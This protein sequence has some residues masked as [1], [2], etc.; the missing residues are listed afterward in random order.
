MHAIQTGNALARKQPGDGLVG[1]DHQVLDQAVGLGLHARANLGDVSAL[2]EDELG[3]LGVDRQR[4]APLAR[5][6]QSASSPARR[7]QRRRPRLQWLLLSGE[8]PVDALVV[9]PFIGADQRAIELRALD[10]RAIEL[11]LGRHRQA[12]SRWHERARV[13][14][15]LLRKHRLDGAW[16]VH[17]RRPLARLD[18]HR[19]ALGH[20]CAHV[21]DVHPHARAACLQRL[22]G[23]RIVEVARAERIDRERRQ[24][25]QVAPRRHVAVHVQA[26]VASTFGRALDV[27]LKPDA[28]GRARASAPRSPSARTGAR[29]AATPRASRIV[30]RAPGVAAAPDGGRS[31]D[32]RGE[33]VQGH[34]ET[35][36]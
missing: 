35:V 21:G 14:G 22:G 32:L 8:D 3:L 6:L 30:A 1:G 2:V 20:I 19:R 16:D 18:V 10:L 28:R 23:D 33:R 12:L 11:Q 5:V 24:V 25:R 9:Q 13:A 26:A 27:A 31:L 36:V 17:A 34:V 15:K 4:A 29:S 7:R